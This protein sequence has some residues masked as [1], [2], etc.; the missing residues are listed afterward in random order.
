MDWIIKSF[1]KYQQVNIINV[2]GLLIKK[3][4]INGLLDKTT[5]Y[6]N[7]LLLPNNWCDTNNTHPVLYINSSLANYNCTTYISI[8][9]VDNGATKVFTKQ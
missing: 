6:N 9:W 4:I 8:I 5:I 7:I 2:A 1:S 3:K